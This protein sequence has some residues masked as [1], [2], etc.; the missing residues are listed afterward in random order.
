MM[1]VQTLNDSET[2][3]GGCLCLQ[4]DAR[5]NFE[6]PKSRLWFYFRTPRSE[7]ELLPFGLSTRLRGLGALVAEKFA[8]ERDEAIVF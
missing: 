1:A 5:R 4:K 6:F 8:D 2:Y 7:L 3:V